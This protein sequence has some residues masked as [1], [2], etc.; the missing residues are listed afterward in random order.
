VSEL[1]IARNITIANL[2]YR[3]IFFFNT[4]H[5]NTKIKTIYGVAKTESQLFEKRLELEKTGESIESWKNSSK[6]IGCW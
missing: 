4:L 2:L 5:L 1:K 6:N 3:F